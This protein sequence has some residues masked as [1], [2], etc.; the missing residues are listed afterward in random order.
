MTRMSLRRPRMAQAVL[1]DAARP[2]GVCIAVEGPIGVGKTSLARL[3]AARLDAAEMLEVVE[4]NPFLHHFYQDIRAYAFQ[5]QIF[6]FLSR[7]RQQGAVRE[8]RERG[9]SVVSDYMFAKDRLFARM[10]LDEHELDLYERLYALIAPMTAQLDLVIYLRA[11]LPTLLRRI[12]RRDRPFERAIEPAYLDRLR[13]AYDAFFADYEETVV[14]TV[15]TDAVD[16]YQAADLD[17][18]LS[19]AGEAGV[20]P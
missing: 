13:R 15:D 12:A 8:H 5:T 16:I 9:R 6:F 1:L 2:P 10:N 3:L 20:P 19:Y 11:E 14:L 4:E 18:I 7:Y 17:E